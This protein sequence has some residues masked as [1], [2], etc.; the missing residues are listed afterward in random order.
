MVKIGIIG[1]GYWGPNLIRN[2]NSLEDC[3]V[4]YLADLR[5]GR[6]DFVKENYPHITTTT[7][8]LDILNDA[9]ISAIV[10]ATPV[11]THHKFAMEALKK[12]KHVYVEKPFTISEVEAREL[13]DLSEEKNL[14]L[15]VGH[16]FEYH[17][18]VNKIKELLKKGIIGDVYYIDAARI[19]MGPPESKYNV[20]WDL[21]P[22]DISIILYLVGKLP[23]FLQAIGV[24][25]RSDQW[26]GLI[27][28]SYITLQ[29]E[30]KSFA[31]IHNSWIS[32]NK[33]RRI[34]IFGSRGVILYDEMRVQKVTV[35]YEGIDTR[36]SGGAKTSTNLSYSTGEIEYPGIP[37]G[38]P[39]KIECQHFV[40][41]VVNNR[42]PRSDGYDGLNVVRIIEKA[43]LSINNNNQ[44]I[45][46]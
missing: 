41:S 14:T 31:Q 44:V 43:E 22:H 15:M 6:L 5:E 2:F 29:F 46:Y 45:K 25:F 10:I 24:D 38:E 37:E 3:E 32:P 26:Q 34:E 7:N 4:K 12:G 11:E 19:N 17:P 13:I 30:D 16:L 28:S 27:Q 40:D 36:K 9:K 1:A 21:A 35:F 20:M 8:Y 23:S 33:T 18:A 42:R 39:L